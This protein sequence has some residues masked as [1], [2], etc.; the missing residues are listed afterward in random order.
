MT[1]PANEFQS[2]HYSFEP[3][4]HREKDI[5][6]IRF[7]YNP[8]LISHLKLHTKCRW[9]QTQKKWYVPDVKHYRELFGMGTRFYSV[10]T[11]KKLNTGNL[12]SLERYIQALQ[13][14]G[15]SD[16]TIRTYTGEFI[17]LLYALKEKPVDDLDEEQLRSYLLYWVEKLKLSENTLHSRINAIKFYFEQVAGREKMF[18]NIPRP[19]KR[20][21]LPKVLSTREIKKMF[22]VTANSKHRL[23]LKLCYGMGLRVSEL[24]RLKV[25][26]IDCDRM[27]VLVRQG[28]GKKDRYA[29]LPESILEDLKA[30]Y[31]E[32]KPGEYLFEGQKG[33]Q[34]SIRSV[35]Q[36]FKNAMLKAGINKKV[37][38]HSLRH[39]YATHLIEQGTD[40]RF[41]QDLLGHKNIKTTMIYTHLTD[42]IRRKIK[43]PLDR[44]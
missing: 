24:A 39:T 20:S 40:I 4:I 41:V 25:A 34:Y 33:G 7:P 42:P 38:V 30:Y 10:K 13:L 11:R 1:N 16:N 32:Y 15:Y 26:D 21:T 2:H 22:Q 28:K 3:G 27:Q 9:S 14:K 23:L 43:S 44:L 18:F 12:K 36:V 29:I 31:R 19:K 6:W 8:E 35:Q 5:I 37:G 17:Q